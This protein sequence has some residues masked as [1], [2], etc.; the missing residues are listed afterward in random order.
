MKKRGVD[1]SKGGVS[2][3]TNRRGVD[4]EQVMDATQRLAVLV[5]RA[6]I[7]PLTDPTFFL[8]VW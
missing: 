7:G 8:V 1:V 5:A 4:R 3:K 2:V 6:S